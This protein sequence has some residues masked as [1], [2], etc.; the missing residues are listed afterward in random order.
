MHFFETLPKATEER[1]RLEKMYADESDE[2][3]DDFDSE[4]GYVEPDSDEEGQ[5]A[6]DQIP[7]EEHDVPDEDAAYMQYLA[8]Q[9]RHQYHI[10]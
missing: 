9:V 4:D 2:Y 5:D 3:D 8:E 7:D 6:F 1:E 10:S